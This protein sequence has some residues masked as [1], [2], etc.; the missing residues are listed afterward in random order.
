MTKKYAKKPVQKSLCFLND[1]VRIR[2][3]PSARH[4]GATAALQQENTLVK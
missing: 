4:S 1:K 3:L 2:A